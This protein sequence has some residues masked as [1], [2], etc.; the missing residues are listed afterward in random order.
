MQKKRLSL[1]AHENRGLT[2]LRQS[3]SG[4][5]G[6]CGK[7]GKCGWQKKAENAL[8]FLC[9]FGKKTQG[10]SPKKNTDFHLFRTPQ[11]SGKEG[12]NG[13]KNKE[14]L[15]RQKSKEIQKSKESKIRVLMIGLTMAGLR[16]G[17]IHGEW[18]CNALV[19]S[20]MGRVRF[21]RDSL[22]VVLPHL[23]VGKKI[24]RFC[25]V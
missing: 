5:R 17:P 21:R 11:I 13:R 18:Q 7:F 1:H 25:L 3:A 8:I 14:F 20:E 19:N 9:F 22:A 10:K 12:E 2:C 24:L 23:P 6:K 16:C 4:K 15:E